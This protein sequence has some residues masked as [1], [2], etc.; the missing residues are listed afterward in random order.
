MTDT[1]HTKRLRDLTG[2]Q[3]AVL[4][5]MTT[6]VATLAVCT[7][8]NSGADPRVCGGIRTTAAPGMRL[9]TQIYLLARVMQERG[10]ERATATG[11]R[12]HSSTWRDDGLMVTQHEVVGWLRGGVCSTHSTLPSPPHFPSRVEV[13][14]T[15]TWQR[16]TQNL[17]RSLWRTGLS[18]GR[19]SREE[20]KRQ[21]YQQQAQPPTALTN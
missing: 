20:R 3:Q 5:A 21:P 8:R 4:T 16:L 19:G 6:F 11:S 9:R 2:A 18:H 7:R 17:K 15:S 1:L 10:L 12:T 14:G 13:R